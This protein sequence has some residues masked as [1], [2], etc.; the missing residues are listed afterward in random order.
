MIMIDW[1]MSHLLTTPPVA[2]LDPSTLKAMHFCGP[3][4]WRGDSSLA[5]SLASDSPP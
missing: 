4:S 5:N 1:N 2:I 3:T